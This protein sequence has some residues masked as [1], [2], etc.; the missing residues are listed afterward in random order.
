MFRRHASVAIFSVLGLVPVTSA[1]A[2]DFKPVTEAVLA[3]PDP[4][5][6]L[7]LNRTHDEQR[8]SP[9]DQINKGNVANLRMAWS[10]GMPPG[11]QESTPMVYAGI[12]YVIAPGGMPRLQAMRRLATLPLLI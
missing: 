3:A 12:M 4:A 7:M 5:D 8:F 11:T 6:W 10:R 1:P 2:A 9:L